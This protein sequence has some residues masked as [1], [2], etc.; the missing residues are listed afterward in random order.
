M[1]GTRMVF[2]VFISYP[3]QEK[4]TAD[5]VCA[6]LEA[7]S[8]RCWI[9]PRDIAPSAE[10]AGA[11][12]EA[13][14][15]CRLMVLIFSAHANRSK[16]V[17]REVQQ[18]F[19]AEK[20]IVP[21]RI[22]NVSPEKSLRYYMGPVHWLDALT[23]PIEKHLEKLTISVQALVRSSVSGVASPP[24]MSPMSDEGKK[25][26]NLSDYL[27]ELTR[28]RLIIGS[29]AFFVVAILAVAWIMF[30]PRPTSLPA[31]SSTAIVHGPS[32]AVSCNEEKSLRSLDTMNP[33][34]ILFLNK[35]SKSKRIYW[36]DF[37]GERKLYGTL[38]QGQSIS[39]Q[40][41]ITHPW[42]IANISD[43]CQA[44]Y[45]PTTAPQTIEIDD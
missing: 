21:F 10:W 44:I 2:D 24:P 35:A 31:Q 38:Q 16:Q 18:A 7:E 39:I 41:Y 15:Q 19:D 25:S 3:H 28:Q 33:T 34:T 20:P 9:A 12:V 42:V 5:A 1:L 17:R 6:K 45:M 27:Q 11:I 36:L 37:N 40:T 22:E 13:I 32:G 29:L 26:G 14:D 43:V 30:R 8:I 4:T 23:P